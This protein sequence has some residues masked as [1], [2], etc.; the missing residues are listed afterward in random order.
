MSVRGKQTTA[1]PEGIVGIDVELTFAGNANQD[2]NSIVSV[3]V[4]VSPKLFRYSKDS[5]I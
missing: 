1:N 3:I 5:R 4:K 2:I